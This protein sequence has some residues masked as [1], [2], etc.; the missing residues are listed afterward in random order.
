MGPIRRS[1]G[2]RGGHVTAATTGPPRPGH[3][4]HRRPTR[5]GRAPRGPG[6]SLGALTWVGW[7]SLLAA[8]GWL[9]IGLAPIVREV[10]PRDWSWGAIVDFLQ[11][12]GGSIALLAVPAAIEWGIPGARARMPWLVRGFALLAL[13]EVAAPV[14]SL[15]LGWAYEAL[16][17]TEGDPMSYPIEI[18]RFLLGLGFSGL[19]IVAMWWTYRGLSAGGARLDRL[20]FRML[21]T[22]GAVLTVAWLPML[23]FLPAN[24]MEAAMAPYQ[25]AVSL[26]RLPIDAIIGAAWFV[27]GGTL[28]AGYQARLRPRRAWMV[29][30]TAGVLLV[31]GVGLSDVLTA[32]PVQP[33]WPSPYLVVTAARV[34]LLPAFLLGLGRGRVRREAPPRRVPQYELHRAAA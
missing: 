12:R 5:V 1:G 24:V 19:R 7:L 4:D 20:A 21:A 17:Q 3:I 18:A 25:V 9:A 6:A 8:L 28:V 23:A 22:A 15:L 33:F 11:W 30:A 29:G 13:L 32:I 10:D 16:P 2:H 14:R 27:I 34:L 26:V 31:L